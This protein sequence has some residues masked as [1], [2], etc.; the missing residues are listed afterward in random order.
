MP[1]GVIEHPLDHRPIAASGERLSAEQRAQAHQG[2]C[3]TS[4]ATSI[5]NSTH[6]LAYARRTSKAAMALPLTQM[7]QRT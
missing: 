6:R 2:S 1:L 5:S 4:S 7:V 3:S